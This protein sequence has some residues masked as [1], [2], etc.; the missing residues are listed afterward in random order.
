MQYGRFDDEN[1]EYVIERPDTPRSWSNYLG[2]TRYGAI[3]TN[4][5][6]GYS[7]FHSAVQGR[8]TRLWFNNV[9]LDQPGRY[10]YLRDRD[11]GDYFSASWQPVAKPLKSYETTCRH[12]TAYTIITSRYGGIRTETTYFVPLDRDYEVWLLEV[13]NE[14]ERPRRLSVFSFLEYAS[15]WAP[16]HDQFNMQYSQYIVCCELVD[17]LIAQSMCKNLPEDPQNFQNRDQSRHTF[18]GVVGATPSGFDTDR[19]TFLGGPYRSYANPLVVERG[20]CT[21]SIAQ[22]DDACGVFQMDL[23]LA[24]G[25]RRELM[26]VLGVGRAATAG[27]AA[28]AEMRTPGDAHAALAAL[29][30]Y[31][32]DRLGALVVESPDA[33]FDSMV[34][35]W[36]AYNCLVTYAWSRA[37]SLVYAGGRDGLGYRDTVQDILGVLPAIPEL[38]RD[39]LELMITGQVSTGGAMPVVKPFAHRPGHEPL[40]DPSEYRS[41]DCLWLFNTIPA[42]VKETGDLDFYSRVLPFADRGEATVLG[43]LRRAIEFNLERS[44][45]HGLPCGLSADWNDTLKLGY[46]GESVFVAFQLRFALATYVELA[47]LRAAPDEAAWARQRLATLDAAL[48]AHCWDD[49]WYVRAFRE[50]GSV[51]G[52]R[53]DPEGSIFLNAQSWA[54]LSGAATG[55]RARRAMQSVNERLATPYGVMLC[56]PPFVKTDVAVVRAVLFNPGMKENGAIFCHPQGWAVIAE[57]LLRNGARAW[58]YYRAYMPAAYNTRAEIRQIEPYVH[59]QSTH[60]RASARFGASRLPWLTG[61]AAWSYFAGT[62]YLLG[63]RPDYAGLRID[64]VVPADWDGFTVRRRFRGAVYDITVENPRHVESGVA[65][66][67]VDGMARDPTEPL[68]VASEGSKVSVRVVLG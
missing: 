54:V 6:G 42:Y 59:C 43:H 30:Q 34:N 12:G 44:G 53:R 47:E 60:G 66:I 22:G 35:V 48:E 17:G 27:K 41:D 20:S 65:S 57:T 46:H 67:E 18:L 55:D 1:R 38:A 7:F 36:N 63:V 52:T 14:S 15:E 56:D 23:E 28:M 11:S 3:V 2:N 8:F 33:E 58:E 62:Q 10:F 51:I 5:A 29:R 25:E 19:G 32:H 31:W 26:V 50:D 9:P 45:A 13:T 64:P 16:Y 37:A 39:R 4:N 24:P 61:T 49:E 40:P 68:P 21:G